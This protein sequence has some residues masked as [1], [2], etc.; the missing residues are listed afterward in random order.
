MSAAISGVHTDRA[1]AAGAASEARLHRPPPPSS[2]AEL[3]PFDIAGM[4]ADAS[5]R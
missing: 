2:S 5:L 4:I 1:T 3:E